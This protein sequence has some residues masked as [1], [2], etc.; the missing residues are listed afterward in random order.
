MTAITR[1]L[2]SLPKDMKEDLQAIA[3]GKGH[4]LNALMLII[5][6]AWLKQESKGDVR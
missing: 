2:L 6:S 4:T 5:L 3:S 1:Y